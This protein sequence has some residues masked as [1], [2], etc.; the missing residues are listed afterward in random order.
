V[1]RCGARVFQKISEKRSATLFAQGGGHMADIQR[2]SV[3]QAHT[4]AKSNQ[5]LLVCAY[6]DEAKCRMLNLDG[7]ISFTSFKSRVNSVPKSQE[8]I[9]Y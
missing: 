2:I 3:Q 9:F 5:A 1:Q 8:I 4:K 6:E 7:S